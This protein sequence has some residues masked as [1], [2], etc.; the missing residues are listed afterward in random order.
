MP[1][2]PTVR[3]QDI[4][5]KELAATHKLYPK[6]TLLDRAKRLDII[7]KWIA[8]CVVVMTNG[9]KLEFTGDK[10]K[11]IWNAWKERQFNNV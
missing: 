4:D 1:T 10:A 3:G 5:E 7:D 9:H 2:K 6:E 8:V 11:S